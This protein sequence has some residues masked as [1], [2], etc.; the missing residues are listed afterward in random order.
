MSKWQM[1]PLGELCLIERGGS[2]R[3]IDKYITDDPNG[4]NWIKIGDTTESMYI[5]RTKERIIPEG[6]KK[7]RYVQKGDFLLSNSMSFGRPYILDI[8]GCIHDGWLVIRDNE[9]VFDKRFLYYFLGSPVTY[10][11]F[12]SMAVGGVVNNLNIDMVKKILVPVLSIAEQKEIAD[13]LDKVTALINYR[14]DQ[15]ANLESLVKSRFIELFGDLADPN[16]QWSALH[17]F[18]ACESA[19]DIKCGPFGT[20]LNK[21][22]YQST[23]VAVWEI[24][25]INN[26]FTSFPTH[27][28]TREKANQLSAYSLIP[29]DIAMS[30]K[31]N[32]GRCAVFPNNFPDGIIHS[33]VLRIRL[34]RSRVLPIFMMYQLHFSRAIQ[35]QIESVSSGAIMA[36]INV[37]KLKNIIV[38]VP[39]IHLQEQFAAFVE[40][41]DK[42]KLAVTEALAELETLKKS[43]MQQYFG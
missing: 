23:G 13:V 26:G 5:T 18:E 15:I 14:K 38:F 34:D 35:Y 21:D 4:I 19:D 8:D 2:P 17:L 32:V 36:G 28:L 12:K 1:R 41:T 27:F 40:Q 22:E 42:L 29:G 10:Q 9:G 3:P 30:R 6:M 43:L 16:C 33:D 7:S 24:P 37:G 25:Q 39:P 11:K 20:Q 31:G